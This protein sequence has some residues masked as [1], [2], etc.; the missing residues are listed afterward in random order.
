[1]FH[2]F[3]MSIG[4]P[5]EVALF[6]LKTYIYPYPMLTLGM[7]K[8]SAIFQKIR[9]RRSIGITRRKCPDCKN[10]MKDSWETCPFC[11][12][13]PEIKLRKKKKRGQ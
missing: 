13:L 3:Y 7:P 2:R 6:F 10:I 4:Q 1:M 9:K 11:K 12:Y 5:F 8:E